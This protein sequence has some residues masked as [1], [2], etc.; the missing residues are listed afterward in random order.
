MSRINGD[1]S[2]HPAD[3]QA[4]GRVE[5]GLTKRELIAAM[6]LQGYIAADWGENQPS[7]LA[8]FAVENADALLEELAK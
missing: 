6:A 3:M 7:L 4:L 2:A 8:R 5:A 1:R